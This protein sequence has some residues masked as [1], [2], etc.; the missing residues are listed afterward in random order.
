MSSTKMVDLD[1][2]GALMPESSARGLI[3]TTR[4]RI[5]WCL[6]LLIL[7]VKPEGHS[8]MSGLDWPVYLGDSASSQSSSLSQINSDNVMNLEIAWMYRCGDARANGRS[9]IQCNPIVVDG[10]LYATTP[11]L[12]LFALDASTGKPLWTFDPSDSGKPL[13]G[14]NRGVVYWRGEDQGRILYTA[15]SFLYAVDSASGKAI[16]SFGQNGRVD[17]KLGLGRDVSKLSVGSRTPGVVFKNLLILGT[18]VAE[19]PGPSAPG[20]LRAYDVVTG[21]QVW[22]FNTIP[23]P[24]E[25]GYETW[26]AQA[27]SYS[28]GANCW[29]GMAVDHER[30]LVFVPTGSPSFDFWGG[31]RIGENLFGNCLLALRAST[32][33]RVWHFQMVH[34]DLWDRDLPAPPNLLTVSHRGK[35]VPAV[36]QVTK[37]GHVFLF[38]RETGE[39]LFPIEEVPV[40]VSDVAGESAWITQ[41]IPTKPGPFARQ[42]FSVDQLTQLSATSRSVV[43]ESFLRARPHQPFDPPSL[44]GT[45]IF[46]GFDGGAEWGGAAVDLKS[47]ILYVNANEM[48]WILTLKKTKESGPARSGEA[49]YQQLCA[50]CHG[51]NREGDLQRTYPG[52]HDL[53]K[54]L[55]REQ[56]LDLLENGKGLMPSAA[57]LTVE[58]REAVAS[59]L[60]NPETERSDPDEASPHPSNVLGGSPF[61]HTGYNRFLDPDGYP[62]IKPP[63][64][65]LNAINLNSG[66]FEWQVTLGEFEE[67]SARGIPPTGTENYGGPIVTD[68]GLIFIGASKD[69]Q[70]RAFDKKTGELLWQT[71]LPAGAYA[72]PATYQVKG[73]QY[74]VIACGGGKMGTKSGDAYVAFALP[75]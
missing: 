74:V 59:F 57:F 27:W 61:S 67:L 13:A 31:D 14:V 65:T 24:G 30:N 73:R 63:W 9:Q 10:V 56:V 33:K 32:G 2:E 60:M 62:A 35:S 40:P 47:G 72:T 39:P 52:L 55:S 44:R 8:E 68:G 34:H 26:P 45:I 50:V 42:K 20:H 11:A 5:I 38:H 12:R 23:H 41:P 4:T 22:R 15:G 69:E 54:R 58:Q 51:L 19:G 43:L 28:G 36:A 6:A 53:S 48:P 49:I 71:K 64:G 7:V 70:F 46:P 37:S 21:E 29:T 1:S 3:V 17:L 75:R 16:P 25:P 18:R 66:E